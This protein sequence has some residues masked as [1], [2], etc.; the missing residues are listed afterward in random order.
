MDKKGNFAHIIDFSGLQVSL[1]SPEK[2]KEWSYGEVTKPETINYR[3]LISNPLVFSAVTFPV[4][5]RAKYT[6]VK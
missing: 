4:F 6:L 3:T 5:G 2:V 1:A